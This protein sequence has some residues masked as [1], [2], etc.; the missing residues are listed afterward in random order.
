MALLPGLAAVVLLLG[1]NAFF[2]AA[3]FSL[4]AVDRARIEA[5]AE[6]GHR[7]DARIRGLLRRLT[8]TMSGCQFGITAAALLLGFVAE[9]TVARLLTGEAHPT[10]LSVVAA[11]GAAT[12]LHLVVGEQ[13]PKYLA[14]AVPE[15][16]AR[17]LAPPLIAY[18]TVT[19]PLV[20]GLNR[21][22]NAV[23]RRLGVETRDQITPSRTRDE[24]EDLIRQSG[25]EGGL[26]REEA[27]LLWRSIRFGDKTA[28]DCLVPRVDLVV[29]GR[30]DTAATLAQRSLA[31]GRSRFLVVGDDLD[32]VL[33]VVHVKAVYRVPAEN[34]PDT[35][36]T[37]LIRD[38]PFVPETRPL[39]DLFADLRSGS[40]Q[41][42]VVVDEHGGTSGILTM[43]DLLEEIVG[44]I[45]D[46]HDRPV[47][48]T[49]VEE[50]GSFVVPGRLNLDE[51]YGATGFEVPEGPYETLAGYLLARLGHLPQPGEM[52]E[53]AGW[54]V[55]VV[56]VA[57]RRIA[58]LRV[59]ALEEPEPSS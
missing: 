15:V 33:G 12:V 57:G 26:E 2:V 38:V 28:V 35:P 46:E 59:V 39:N 34:R 49:R 56:A 48:R 18:S 3:E 16:T 53:E 41:L 20:E 5:S 55:E 37:D 7:G 47:A 10:G 23:A 40:G 4:V 29:L 45:D 58:T 51:V 8:P 30:D 52:V 42:A 32:D 25:D 1:A 36:V 43:E 44:D 13:V 54:R 6:A 9:P 27:D 14:I 21:S 24:L 31:T 22:A 17:R 50:P 11:I 19:R